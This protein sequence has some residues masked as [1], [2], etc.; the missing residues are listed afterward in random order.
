MYNL[1]NCNFGTVINKKLSH[2]YRDNYKHGLNFAKYFERREN[3]I[4]V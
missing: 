1:H 4:K 2:C 3:K